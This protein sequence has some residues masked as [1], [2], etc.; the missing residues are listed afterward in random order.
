MAL[1]QP[2][3]LVVSSGGLD[4]TVAIYDM[5]DQGCEVATVSFEYGQ[6][7]RKELDFAIATAKKLGIR[8]DV[9]FLGE[10]NLTQI[11]AE[12]GSSLVSDTAVPEGHYAEDNMKQ[13]VVPNRNMMM[14]SIAGS[15]AVATGC[16]FIVT[17]VHAGDHA[18]YPDCRPRFINLVSDALVQGNEGFGDM[19][20][21]LAPYVHMSKTEIAHKGMQLKVPFHE[22]WSC[23]KGGK[24]HCGKCGT[25]VERLEAIYEA[26]ATNYDDT[27]YED[28]DFW[29]TVTD[30]DLN[31]TD[32][33]VG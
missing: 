29:K 2:K 6:R 9:I 31:E 21:V 4:S 16:N 5:L 12:S 32:S 1:N 11:L 8:H 22:T 13:T 20:G 24:L 19:R 14:L 27:Q 33:E 23:Y 18:V 3:A 17:G 15:V 30:T 10:S 25:C 26:G 28:K 7:H